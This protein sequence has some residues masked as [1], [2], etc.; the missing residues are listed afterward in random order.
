MTIAVTNLDV[1]IALF[2]LSIICF[3]MAGSTMKNDTHLSVTNPVLERQ[4]RRSIPGMAHFAGTGPRDTTC[5]TCAFWGTPNK[6]R[7]GKYTSD[8]ARERALRHHPGRDTVLQVL[9]GGKER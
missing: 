1:I 8:D 5:Y 2:S 6:N 9:R 4:V 7:C 3:S